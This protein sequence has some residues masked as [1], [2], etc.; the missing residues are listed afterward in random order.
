MCKRPEEAKR[1]SF[2]PLWNVN[3][4]GKEYRWNSILGIMR[5]FKHWSYNF[6]SLV[7]IGKWQDFCS[8][9]SEEKQMLNYSHTIFLLGWIFLSGKTC[10][11]EVLDMFGYIKVSSER[12]K[13]LWGQK[14]QSIQAGL[15]FSWSSNCPTLHRFPGA[16]KTRI[17]TCRFLGKTW[18]FQGLKTNGGLCSSWK[19]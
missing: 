9:R 2:H 12:K 19:F 15:C 10:S 17:F 1:H 11:V 3:D 16:E 18:A 14:L 6:L 5:K 13:R 7:N 4:L 8:I